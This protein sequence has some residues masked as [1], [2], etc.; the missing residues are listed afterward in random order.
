MTDTDRTDYSARPAWRNQ[1]FLILASAA[2]FVLAALLALKAAPALT[3]KAPAIVGGRVLAI[4][5]GL[6]GGLALALFALAAYRHYAWSFTIGD[7]AIE[8]RRGIIGRDV[9]SI[10]VVD[11]RNVNVHQSLFQR[12]FNVGNVEFS[13][14]GGAGVEVVF[15]GVLD[16]MS[17]KQRVYAHSGLR[18][19]GAD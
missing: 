11:L 16:P 19:H 17:V 1:W 10:R 4:A 14:A 5:P 15:Y 2:L 7:G 3:F 9:R 18:R 6:A 12:L 13:S 8:S